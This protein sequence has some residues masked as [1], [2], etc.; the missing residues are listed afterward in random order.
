MSILLPQLKSS[1]A[2]VSWE[3]ADAWLFAGLSL[4]SLVL[5]GWLMRLWQAHGVF[6]QY[7]IV[8]DA[9]PNAGLGQFAHGSIPYG[10][11]AGFAH[12]ILPFFLSV[13]F[14][15]IAA[16]LEGAHLISDPSLLRESMA[17]WVAP[18]CSAVKNVMPM[19]ISDRRT[20]ISVRRFT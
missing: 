1:K 12:P 6:V 11:A 14:R 16:L 13:P 4:V 7:N 9:D 15:V 2:E 10:S 18:T 17:L 20:C 3:T 19:P 5:Y 8:F